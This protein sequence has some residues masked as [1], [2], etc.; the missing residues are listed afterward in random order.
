MRQALVD[1]ITVI[2]PKEEA[3]PASHLVAHHG[4]LVVPV[5]PSEQDACLTAERPN[6]NP[7]LRPAIVRLRW[8]VL[9]KLKAQ[10]VDEE[11][12]RG[13]VL[14][15]DDRDEFEMHAASVGNTPGLSGLI[16]PAESRPTSRPCRRSTNGGRRLRRRDFGDETRGS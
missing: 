11:L 10:L 16:D 13:V 5:G 8:R 6:D 7:S 12:D 1:G 9:H 3:N 15:H 2:D 4:R 14:V